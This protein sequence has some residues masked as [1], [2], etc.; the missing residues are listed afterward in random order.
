MDEAS[1]A[2]ASVYRE[3]G[4]LLLSYEPHPPIPRWLY[5]LVGGLRVPLPP[6]GHKTLPDRWM[7][8]SVTAW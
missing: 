2:E 7:D 1:L 6:F 3:R 5:L 8:G 4:E